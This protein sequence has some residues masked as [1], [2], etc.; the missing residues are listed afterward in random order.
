LDISPNESLFIKNGESCVE[1]FDPELSEVR[2]SISTTTTPQVAKFFPSG[3]VL[4]I[5]DHNI[6]R[7]ADVGSGTVVREM[8]GHGSSVNGIEFIGPGRNFISVSSDGKCFIW[9]TSTGKIISTLL[10]GGY[11]ALNSTCLGSS[12]IT[13]DERPE[14]FFG[15]GNEFCW[16]GT[17]SGDIIG[18]SILGE[19]CEF[20]QNFG[21]SINVLVVG[22]S[23]TVFAGTQD[24][25]LILVK[26]NN[27]E[28][29]ATKIIKLGTSAIT[30]LA[31][32]GSSIWIGFYDGRMAR[33]SQSDVEFEKVELSGP[34]CEPVLNLFSR[35]SFYSMSRDGMLRSYTV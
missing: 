31:T 3:Q 25:A 14:L 21:S 10:D 15:D 29:F 17:E 5:A 24:G 8:L 28:I 22:D 12:S 35:K 23:G 30:S 16:I 20:L 9:E 34:D 7:I 11:G 18:K 19:K 26:T 13:C 1:I 6:L 33:F 32:R 27:H 4:L 2:R